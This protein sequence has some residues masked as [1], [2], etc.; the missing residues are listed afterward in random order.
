M[1]ALSIRQPWAWLVANGHKDIENRD[2]ATNFRG[3][4]LIHAAKGMTRDEYE[5]ARDFAAYNG[6]TI[7]A[8]HELERGGIVGEA[9]I[10]GCVDRCNSLWFFGRYGFELAD[11]KPLP[12]QPMKGQLGFFEVEVVQ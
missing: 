4:F 1:K 9:S 10:I 8:P 3:R 6:V 12:F 7:P 2:W 11:A 5:E